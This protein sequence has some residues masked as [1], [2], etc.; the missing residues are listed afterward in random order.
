[1]PSGYGVCPASS[2]GWGALWNL[3]SSWEPRADHCG[4]A[5]VLSQSWKAVCE[6]EEVSQ[7]GGLF[8]KRIKRSVPRART[9]VHVEIDG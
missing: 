3:G 2:V 4:E 1:M 7:K 6:G 8:R 5:T 9:G